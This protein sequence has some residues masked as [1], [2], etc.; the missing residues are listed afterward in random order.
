MYNIGERSE[1]DNKKVKTTVGPPPLLPIKSLRKTPPLTNL[2]GGGGVRTPSGSA[3]G[4]QV[5]QIGTEGY[6]AFLLNNLNHFNVRDSCTSYYQT[7]S[8]YPK[9]I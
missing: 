7:H 3:L 2:K 1:F 8:I 5:K 4:I 6:D 9:T